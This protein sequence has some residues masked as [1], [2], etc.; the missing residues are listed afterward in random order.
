[1]VIK[2]EQKVKEAIEAYVKDH[3]NSEVVSYGIIRSNTIHFSSMTYLI[4]VIVKDSIENIEFKVT[5]FVKQSSLKTYIRDGYLPTHIIYDGY[6]ISRIVFSNV[7]VLETVSA[8]KRSH[9]KSNKDKDGVVGTWTIGDIKPIQSVR[10][11]VFI[12][13][14][15]HEEVKRSTININDIS[16]SDLVDTK[17]EKCGNAIVAALRNKFNCSEKE[18][19]FIHEI[20]AATIEYSICRLI[21]DEGGDDHEESW[22]TKND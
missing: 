21:R 14:K 4:N 6:M 7:S 22:N 18:K 11:P 2:D 17:L 1:M 10:K 13:G 8:I 3:Y 20:K 5:D 16:V 12:G 9:P 19:V 15:L